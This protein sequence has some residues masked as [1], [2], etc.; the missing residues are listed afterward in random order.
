MGR[1][2]ELVLDLR[3]LGQRGREF[4]VEIVRCPEPRDARGL[5]GL[6]QEAGRNSRRTVRPRAV[7]RI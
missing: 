2:I 7:A 6:R 4:S 3:S 1:K 5:E